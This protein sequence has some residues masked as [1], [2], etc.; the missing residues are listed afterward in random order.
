MKEG[1]GLLVY[2]IV[3]CRGLH[4]TKITDSGSDDLL[5]L[6]CTICISPLHARVLTFH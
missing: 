3:I 1:T 4:M 2:N 6:I 5:T